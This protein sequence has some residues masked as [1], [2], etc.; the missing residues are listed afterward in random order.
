MFVSLF[1]SWEKKFQVCDLKLFRL[2]V[3]YFVS[4]AKFTLR[5]DILC[6]ETSFFE[7]ASL[8]YLSTSIVD[9]PDVLIIVI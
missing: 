3:P 4:L 6:R 1:T 2:L 8:L 7:K 5:F 9:F